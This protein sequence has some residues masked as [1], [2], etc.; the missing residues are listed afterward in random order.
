MA[1]LYYRHG[2]M[3]SSKSMNLIATAHNYEDQ[4]K[5][6]L[7]LTSDKDNRSKPNKVESRANME[8]PAVPMTGEENLLELMLIVKKRTIETGKPV[9]CVLVDECQLFPE[10]FIDVLSD[11][12]DTVEIPVICYGLRTD[13]MGRLFPSSKR[14]FEVADKIEEV[15]TTCYVC[16]RKAIMNLRVN[17]EGESVKEGEQI[18]IGD[19]G[20]FP[21]CRVHYHLGIPTE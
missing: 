19:D 20:Y 21:V 13:Y 2:A 8:W 14:L 9:S 18:I 7:V 1:K 17:S 16:N 15:K 11:L 3:G 4:G 10:G 12:V 5:S 6:V